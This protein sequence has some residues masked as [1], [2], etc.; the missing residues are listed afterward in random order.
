MND[1]LNIVLS[2]ARDPIT[3]DLIV[4]VRITPQLLRSA[5]EWKWRVVQ[6]VVMALSKQEGAV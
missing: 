5:D 3:D 1:S 2:T 6:S 4:R